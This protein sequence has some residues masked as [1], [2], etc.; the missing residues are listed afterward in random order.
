MGSQAITAGI[1]S[2]GIL[3]IDFLRYWLKSVAEASSNDTIARLPETSCLVWSDE[4]NPDDVETSGNGEESL[5]AE[6]QY[7]SPIA[8]LGL[9]YD[10][11]ANAPIAASMMGAPSPIT[12]TPP[13]Q[14]SRAPYRRVVAKFPAHRGFPN[15]AGTGVE[16]RP[17]FSLAQAGVSLPVAGTDTSPKHK[18]MAAEE[19]ASQ[20][21]KGSRLAPFCF[22]QVYETDREMEDPSL[23]LRP[24]AL[25]SNEGG[26]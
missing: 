2:T 21:M 24:A 18:V 14:L 10:A 1:I 25:G 17:A 15:T 20:R 13:C 4:I 12:A 22:G 23:A 11:G 16:K 3:G 8:I 6:P 9:A 5:G 26:G 7:L 19:R